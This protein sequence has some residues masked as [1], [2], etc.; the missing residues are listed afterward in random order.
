[1]KLTFAKKK[2]VFQ[3]E[4]FMADH[5]DQGTASRAFVQAVDST[6]ANIRWITSYLEEVNDWLNEAVNP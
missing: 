3:L 4:E 2:S 5:P 1:M 6:K